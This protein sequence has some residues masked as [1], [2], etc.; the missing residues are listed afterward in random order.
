[1]NL[2]APCLRCKEPVNFDEDDILTGFDGDPVKVMHRGCM[3]ELLLIAE[4][5]RRHHE[6]G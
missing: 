3:D 2:Y 6:D 5:I 1:M 4:G